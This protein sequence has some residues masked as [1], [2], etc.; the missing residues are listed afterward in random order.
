MFIGE[1][2]C[3]IPLLWAYFNAKPKGA[4]NPQ[5]SVFTRI[6]S[7]IPLGTGSTTTPNDYTPVLADEDSSEDGEDE[8]ELV[9]RRLDNTLSGWRMCLMWF[10][11][12]F[13]SASPVLTFFALHGAD[14]SLRHDAHERR[15]DP[16]PGQHI[17]DVAGC[18][19]S[20][21]RH[22]VR[23]PAPSALAVPVDIAHHCHS[24]RMPRRLVRQP[25][26]EGA[27]RSSPGRC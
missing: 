27:E 11:A 8:D 13:D 26:E 5:A 18:A 12:F 10:P 9:Q 19:C 25:G 20:L 24:G 23:H 21:G 1:F 3:C 16:H 7:R 17:P 22:L 2:F 6:L 14:P 15:T 4:L